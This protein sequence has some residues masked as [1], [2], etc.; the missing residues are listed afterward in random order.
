ME[1]TILRSTEQDNAY[2]HAQLRAYNRNYMSNF[3]EYNYHIEQDGKIIAGIV[4]QST[5]DTLEVEFLY[6]EEAY[7][8]QDLGTKLLQHA[9]HA[10]QMRGLNRILVNSYSFQA[11][12]F[13]K[14]LGYTE[15]FKI[16]PCFGEFSQS[17]FI[18]MLQADEGSI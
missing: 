1:P 3:Q 18:K 9:E 4:A 8:K 2:I 15:L 17:Y 5:F 10:A 6:V 13:Y 7:R 16:D 11:P 12:A 14:K